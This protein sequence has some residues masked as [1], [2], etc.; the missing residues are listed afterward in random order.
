MD[1]G[2]DVPALEV[3]TLAAGESTCAE[4]AD[5]CALPVTIVDVGGV[6]FGSLRAGVGGS[7]PD[8]DLP[9]DAGDLVLAKG[10]CRARRHERQRAECAFDVD[11]SGGLVVMDIT[12]LQT[13]I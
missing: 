1:A 7:G 6:K 3:A 13:C 10:G 8:G 2:L 4:A 12:K 9:R 11:L 5:G